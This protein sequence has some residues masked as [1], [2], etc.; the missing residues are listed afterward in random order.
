MLSTSLSLALD[1]S[2]ELERLNLCLPG[3]L[4]IVSKALLIVYAAH[5]ETAGDEIRIILAIT[6]ENQMVVAMYAARNKVG[7]VRLTRMQK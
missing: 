3:M 5:T 7:T 1:L 6:A 2:W 4:T